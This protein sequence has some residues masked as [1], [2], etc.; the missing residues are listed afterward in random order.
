MT[1]NEIDCKRLGSNF[2]LKRTDDINFYKN[3][4]NHSI[5]Q[6][7]SITVHSNNFE[8]PMNVFN[9]NHNNLLKRIQARNINLS[10]SSSKKSQNEFKIQQKSKTAR[11]R[12]NYLYLCLG[13]SNESSSKVIFSYY[14]PSIDSWMDSQLYQNINLN[15]FFSCFSYKERNKILLFGGKFDGQR[16]NEIKKLSLSDL[17]EISHI[18]PVDNNFILDCPKSGFAA[19][20]LKKKIV[21][22]AGGNN[23]RTILNNFESYNLKTMSHE[24]LSPM[25]IPRDELG[26]ALSEIIR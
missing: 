14:N 18:N 16:T 20:V 2:D 12:K 26:L 22:L 21:Y 8:N 13:G 9:Y 19:L 15:K 5:N 1:N 24:T 7:K 4:S 6:T 11:G 25:N 10:L 17:E 23:G 3:E